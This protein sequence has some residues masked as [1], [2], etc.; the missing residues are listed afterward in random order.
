MNDFQQTLA[1]KSDQIN[2]TDLAGGAQTITITKINVNMKEDQP[3]SVSFQGSDKVYRPCKGMRRV[4]AEIWGVDPAQYIGRSLTLYRDPDVRFGADTTGGT[5]ISHMSHIDGEKKVTVPVSRGKVKSYQIKLLSMAQRISEAV[6]DQIGTEAAQ[7]AAR[8]AAG[9]GKAAFTA[10]WNGDGRALRDAVK[11]I[12]P[13]L[14]KLAADAD[15][16]PP[17]NDDD[18]PPM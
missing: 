9:Q 12:M 1:A 13:E 4:M 7:T 17:D 16:P 15:G 10:W 18:A 8:A 5:R 14:T 6:H 3:V 11:P 2:N